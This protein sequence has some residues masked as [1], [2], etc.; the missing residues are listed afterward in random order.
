MASVTKEYRTFVRGI[1]TEASP[2]TFP[3]NASIDEEN[4][5]LNRDGSRQRRLGM[6]Y[7]ENFTLSSNITNATF[8]DLAVHTAEWRNVDNN[9]LTN[10]SV[11]QIGTIIYFYDLSSVPLS[12][13]LKSF[14][15]DLNTYKTLYASNIGSRQISTTVGKGILYIVSQ[16]TVPLYVEY[17]SA[18]D[19]ISITEIEVKIRDFLGVDDGLDVDE[20]PATL[21]TEHNYNL[22]NQGWTAT[23]ISSFVAATA[24]YPSNA[25]IWTLGKDSSDNFSSSLLQKQY[26]GNT[27]APK[28]HF[29]LDA[30]TRDRDAVSGL[31]GITTELEQGRPDATA[32]YAGRLFYAGVASTTNAGP[33]AN[34]N[35]YFSQSLTSELKSGYCYQDADPTA[36]EISDLIDTDGGVITIPE[37]GRILKL[38][39]LR[40]SLVVFADN[41]VW[42]ILGDTGAGFIAT[43]YQVQKISTVGTINADS[44][45]AVESIILYWATSGIY[46]VQPDPNSG[47]LSSSNTTEVTIQTLY[48]DIPSVSKVYS[49]GVYDVAAKRITWLYN[50]DD[51]YDGA[52]YRFN[53]NKELVFDTVLQ[54]FYKNTIS[55]LATLS[56]YVAGVVTTPNLVTA[57]IAYNV[58]D[59]GSQVQVGGVDVQVSL[60]SS[61]RGSVST[62]YLIVE[63]QDA[64]NS[65]VTW[66]QYNNTN[67]LEWEMADGVGIDFSSFLRTGHEI[68]QDTM[69]R[70]YVPY[71]VTHFSRTETGFVDNGT[72]GLDAENPSGCQMQAKWG[73][74]DSANSGKWSNSQQLY[75]L[76]RLYIPTS[77][78][79]LFDYGYEVVTTKSKLRGNGKAVSLHFTSESGKDMHLLGWG[80]SGM[81]SSTV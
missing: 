19:T 75:R 58:I 71:L 28:G 22:L 61:T 13:G 21:S 16:D 54:A 1:I 36:E 62:K 44:I 70:K 2:L 69:R 11:V 25:D 60:P 40:D 51:D 59:G 78:S 14:T 31:T 55:E 7:E 17:D 77:S 12:D 80:V 4:F 20:R 35:I 52:T 33:T 73:W 15:I 10:F 3:E 57:D 9:P 72:G 23:H 6:D 32:F 46:I 18:G 49:R 64:T 41:G 37:V 47:L 8:E 45:V 76:N 29:V 56:P 79:D 24:T 48:L 63:P 39:S 81:G 27:P 26:F 50:D 68:F 43:S 30:F 53:Y 74:S 42:Q 5:I 67:F 65:K 38:V 34:G 66:G